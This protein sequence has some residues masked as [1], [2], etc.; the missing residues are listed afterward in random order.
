MI[1]AHFRTACK[2]DKLRLSATFF[3]YLN[4]VRFVFFSRALPITEKK[5]FNS[6]LKK[7][8][9]KFFHKMTAG[10]SKYE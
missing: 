9:L 1:I 7:S 3:N 5:Q 4:L 10:F 6:T 8:Y 2:G